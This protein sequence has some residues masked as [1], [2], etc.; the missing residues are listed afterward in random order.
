MRPPGL[1]SESARGYA[2]A[3][4][5]NY[6]NLKQVLHGLTAVA[7]TPVSQIRW[8]LQAGWQV[9]GLATAALLSAC[10]GTPETPPRP[11]LAV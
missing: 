4:Q 7:K 8:R 9:C 2:R 6:N 1:A 11:P 3:W 10:Q 5:S